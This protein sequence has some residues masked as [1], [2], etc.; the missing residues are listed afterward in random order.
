MTDRTLFCSVRTDVFY[1]I[2]NEFRIHTKL[3]GLIN[4]CLNKTYLNVWTGKYLSDTFPTQNTMK[5]GDALSPLPFKF[6]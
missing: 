3:E 6:L 1:N 4:M 5:E 2:L